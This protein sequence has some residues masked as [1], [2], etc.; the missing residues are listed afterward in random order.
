MDLIKE[1]Y[2]LLNHHLGVE[3]RGSKKL[4]PEHDELKKGVQRLVIHAVKFGKTLGADAMKLKVTKNYSDIQEVM[5]VKYAELC[6]DVNVDR[7]ESV[8]K[9]TE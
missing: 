1:T 3:H 2:D 6:R 8:T 5:A 4:G 7:Y 9:S